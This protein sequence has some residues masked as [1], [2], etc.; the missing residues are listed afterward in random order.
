MKKWYLLIL[1]LIL[2]GAG[3]NT[4]STT[5]LEVP[6][7][8]FEDVDEMIVEDG[9]KTIDEEASGEAVSFNISGSN[10]AFSKTEMRV[11][12][13]DTVTV[14][15]DSE[16]GFH[17]W[18]VDAYDAATTQVNTGG[19]TSVTFVADQTGTF[20]YYCGVGNHRAQGMVGTLIVE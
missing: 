14:N 12:K 16:S 17:N 8:G 9:D 18:T 2:I 13:G 10:F 20:E 7:P 15:F 19:S 5:T 4:T 1:P 6:A 3:C 11:K